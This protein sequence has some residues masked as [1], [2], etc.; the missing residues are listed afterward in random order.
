MI[1]E[2]FSMLSLGQL[3]PVAGVGK[4]LGAA[5]TKKLGVINLPPQY[6]QTD[7]KINPH[8]KDLLWA[9][10]LTED[11]ERFAVAEGILQVEIA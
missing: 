8:T 4:W 2:L 7:T 5:L 10:V 9:A 1:K 6:W 3:P 11:S